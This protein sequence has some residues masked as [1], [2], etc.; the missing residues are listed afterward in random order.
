M[1]FSGARCWCRATAAPTAPHHSACCSFPRRLVRAV[2]A[3]PVALRR[4][5]C[6]PTLL[7]QPPCCRACDPA[8]LCVLLLLY[9]SRATAPAPK[10]DYAAALA[11]SRGGWLHAG[12]HQEPTVELQNF[13]Q[14]LLP[15][16]TTNQDKISTIDVKP[17][18]LADP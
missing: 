13:K 10:A 9:C 1:V 8:P 16:N 11:P 17:L 7:V 2:R 3:V 4:H 14:K 12:A 18:G 5:T 6:C 15:Q